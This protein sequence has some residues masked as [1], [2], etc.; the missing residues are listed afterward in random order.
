MKAFYRE[1]AR[2]RLRHKARWSMVE[3]VSKSDLQFFITFNSNCEISETSMRKR[4]GQWAARVDRE[5]LG[6]RFREFTEQ[7][8]FFVGWFEVA[9]SR[10]CHTLVRLPSFYAD[11][12]HRKKLYPYMENAWRKILP[13][14]RLHV[15]IASLPHVRDAVAGYS[16]KLWR[17]DDYEDRFIISTEFHPEMPTKKR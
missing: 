15:E 9:S 14:G 10:H 1:A 4:I 17:Q 11:W 3:W 16:T 5:A 7:R 8:T 2:Q 6:N 12:P 13:S